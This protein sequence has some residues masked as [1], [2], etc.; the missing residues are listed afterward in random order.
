MT[1]QMEFSRAKNPIIVVNKMWSSGMTAP[2]WAH[3]SEVADGIGFAAT[4]GTELVR[5]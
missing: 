4:A 1:L 3:D 5:R 2:V